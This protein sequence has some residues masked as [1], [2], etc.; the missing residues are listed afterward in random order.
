ME[1]RDDDD[2]DEVIF[3]RILLRVCAIKYSGCHRITSIWCHTAAAA[4][5]NE[6]PAIFYARESLSVTLHHMTE[7]NGYFFQHHRGATRKSRQQN[8]LRNNVGIRLLK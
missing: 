1:L 7:I 6:L 4:L 3:I 2:D 8:R 5:T